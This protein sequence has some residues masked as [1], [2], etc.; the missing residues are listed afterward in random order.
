MTLR[1]KL[2][3]RIDCFTGWREKLNS[4]DRFVKLFSMYRFDRAIFA[5]NLPGKP[6]MKDQSKGWKV[7]AAELRRMAAKS[8][9][10]ERERKLLVLAQQFEESALRLGDRGD[11]STASSP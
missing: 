1:I 3:V 9:E 11:P 5:K 4:N 2:R 7:S 8:Q 6:V 10:A